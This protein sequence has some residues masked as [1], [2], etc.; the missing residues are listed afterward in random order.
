MIVDLNKLFETMAYLRTIESV[1][2]EEITWILDG[3][4]VK[5]AKEQ[6]ESHKYSGLNNRDF[7][8]NF[9]IQ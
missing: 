4:P 2:L 6:V 7:A 5:V 3:V 1:P 9:N 8:G